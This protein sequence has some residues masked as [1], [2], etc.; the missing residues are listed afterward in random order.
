MGGGGEG[1]GG[2]G[3]ET[4]ETSTRF[5]LLGVSYLRGRF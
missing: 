3:R 2:G 1:R 5:C 4:E